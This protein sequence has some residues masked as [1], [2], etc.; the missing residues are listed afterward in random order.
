MER[1]LETRMVGKVK[2]KLT[3]LI[4]QPI[5][6]DARDWQ[7]MIYGDTIHKPILQ[8]YNCDGWL[9]TA[10]AVDVADLDA[11]IIKEVEMLYRLYNRGIEVLHRLYL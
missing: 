3:N 6:F 1:G 5:R 4:L 10:R 8:R 7:I 11:A 2:G 9:S